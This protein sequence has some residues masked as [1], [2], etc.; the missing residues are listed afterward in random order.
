MHNLGHVKYILGIEVIGGRANRTM[1]LS[2]LGMPW[3]SFVRF[4]SGFLRTQTTP[5]FRPNQI[6][7]QFAHS[8]NQFFWGVVARM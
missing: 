7:N 3:F 5:Y 8:S 6:V 4:R 2:Q 1:Y